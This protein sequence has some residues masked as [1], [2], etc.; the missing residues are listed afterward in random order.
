[1]I[2]RGH[3]FFDFTGP[4]A[5]LA[6]LM[7]VVLKRRWS[8]FAAFAAFIVANL[9]TTTVLNVAYGSVSHQVYRTLYFCDDLLI[10]G[11]Q[12]WIIAEMVYSVIRPSGK[13]NPQARRRFISYSLFGAVAAILASYLL[14][15]THLSGM[16]LFLLRVEVIG[17]LLM[18]EAVVAIMLAAGP[19]GLGWTSHVIAIGQGMMVLSLTTV[20][21]DGIYLYAPHSSPIS[22]AAH[23]FRGILYLATILYWCVALWREEPARKPISP[24]LRKYIVALHDQ[25]QYDLS[26]V[27]H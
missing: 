7:V 15:P 20:A 26:K 19:F 1:M 23:Y 24:A 8:R 25:V 5:N 6:L 17:D 18:T 2:I 13:W 10:F 22:D 11:L 3:E 12:I 14:Q 9:A 16:E 21:V 27:R 4:L